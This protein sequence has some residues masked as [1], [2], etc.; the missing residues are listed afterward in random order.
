[1]NKITVITIR[2]WAVL[3]VIGVK[4]QGAYEK[5]MDQDIEV[6]EGILSQMFSQNHEMGLQQKQVNGNYFRGF[7]LVFKVPR[8]ANYYR[9]K[10]NFN[11]LYSGVGHNNP[12]IKIGH[13]ISPENEK[14]SIYKAGNIH[15]KETV[16]SFFQNYG[17]LIDQLDPNDNIM[18]IF[19]SDTYRQSDYWTKD[20]AVSGKLKAADTE[21]V[22]PASKITAEISYKAILDYKQ[23]KINGDQ[24]IQNIKFSERLLGETSKQEFVILTSIFEKLYQ[25]SSGGFNYL[26]QINFERIDG[27]GV[28]YEVFFGQNFPVAYEQKILTLSLGSDSVRING[29]EWNVKELADNNQ[30]KLNEYKKQ[31]QEAYQEFKLNLKQ[32]LIKYG[33]TLKSLKDDEI[34]LLAAKLQSCLGCDR[35]EKLNLSIK[36]SFL[37]DYDQQKITLYRAAGK[38]I[39]KEIKMP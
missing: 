11:I 16:K 25:R 19:G 12:R 24:F 35:P 39:E 23:G 17:D 34:L 13:H 7:G 22:K 38:I 37:K 15:F 1:M 29:K 6:M 30:Q 27:L 2:L 18:V 31:R 3:F 32:N 10:N 28:I 8:H 9:G 5:Q 4:A 20:L 21:K 26:Q 14:D 36:A 33:K